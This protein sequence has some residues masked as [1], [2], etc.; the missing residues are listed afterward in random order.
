MAAKPEEFL[1]VDAPLSIHRGYFN[2]PFDTGE[3]LIDI[4]FNFG[5]ALVHLTPI[6]KGTRPCTINSVATNKIAGT[7]QL[8][9]SFDVNNS[10]QLVQIAYTLFVTL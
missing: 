8:R 3:F 7:T 1:V 4:G 9:V 5:G 2:G 10:T 6:S